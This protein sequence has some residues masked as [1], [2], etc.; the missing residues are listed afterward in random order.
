[1]YQAPTTINPVTLLE[2]C[3]ES[4]TN[5]QCTPKSPNSHFFR[6]RCDL[7]L[8]LRSILKIISNREAQ[9]LLHPPKKTIKISRRR[10]RRRRSHIHPSDSFKNI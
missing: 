6:F 9:G 8:R 1:M 3:T 7:R 5:S 10:R 2:T 4:C